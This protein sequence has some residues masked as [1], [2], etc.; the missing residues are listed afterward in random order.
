MADLALFLSAY[1]PIALLIAVVVQAV[2]GARVR[3]PPPNPARIHRER[4]EQ[5]ARHG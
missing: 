3:R 5:E 1:G 4:L 2:Y